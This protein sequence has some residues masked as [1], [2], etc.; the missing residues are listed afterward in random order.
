VAV[1]FFSL[2]LL[3]IARRLDMNPLLLTGYGPTEPNTSHPIDFP[4][5][6]DGGDDT[7]APLGGC[8]PG[9]SVAVIASSSC[10]YIRQMATF[11]IQQPRVRLWNNC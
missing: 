5:V 1:H 7:T 6:Q 11:N 4:M 8:D 10:I 9:K 2:L 3:A